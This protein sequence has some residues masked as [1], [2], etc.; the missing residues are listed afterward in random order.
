MYNAAR[1]YRNL[2]AIVNH[3]NKEKGM[4]TATDVILTGCSGNKI[5]SACVCN[6]PKL[7]LSLTAGGLA[8][9]LHVDFVQTLIVDSAKYMAFPDAG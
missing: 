5:D 7:S 2:K 8:V 3:L 1:G 9:F 6:Q 4:S